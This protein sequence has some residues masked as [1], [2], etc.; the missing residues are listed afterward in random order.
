[1][2]DQGEAVVAEVDV[3]EGLSG[4]GFEGMVERVGPGA[5]VGLAVIGLGEDVSDPDGDEPS[6]GESLMVG[7]G[8][9][10]LV[11]EMGE[12]KLDQESEEQRDVIDAFVSQLQGSFHGVAPTSHGGK[13]RCIAGEGVSERSRNNTREHGQYR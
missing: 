7:V 11:E 2:E 1:L 3:A 6:L 4:D 5:D 13:P 9:E 8:L 10:V 12:T